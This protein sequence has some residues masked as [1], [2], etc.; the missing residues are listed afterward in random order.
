MYSTLD[1]FSLS[2]FFKNQQDISKTW[3]GPYLLQYYLFHEEQIKERFGDSR[4]V[5]V[6]RKC[7]KFHTFENNSNKLKLHIN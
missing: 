7:G 2:S 6:I 1:L 4:S 5:G 3:S